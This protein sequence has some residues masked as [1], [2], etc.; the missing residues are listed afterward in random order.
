MIDTKTKIPRV[1]INGTSLVGNLF[2]L[3]EEE[4]RM[5]KQYE[6]KA[7]QIMRERYKKGRTPVHDPIDDYLQFAR[8]IL[9]SCIK[10]YT[11]HPDG[12]GF[13]VGFLETII[14]REYYKHSVR[15]YNSV[16]M[17]NENK[18]MVGSIY[19]PM[20]NSRYRDSDNEETLLDTLQCKEIST[21]DCVVEKLSD[22]K[23]CIDIILGVLKDISNRKIKSLDNKQF[24]DKEPM[25]AKLMLR[26]YSTYDMAEVYKEKYKVTESTSRTQVS[27]IMKKIRIIM[28]RELHENGL[29][30]N[31]KENERM[32]EYKGDKMTEFLREYL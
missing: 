15:G 12:K 19:E 2:D 24:S 23:S 26:G 18:N 29:C 16:K 28:I 7:E 11:P 6:L 9:C 1:I 17:T 27:R 22:D 32:G 3:N 14:R 5:Y 21:E 31:I 25:V 20:L 30:L 4:M 10:I 8:I 13:F